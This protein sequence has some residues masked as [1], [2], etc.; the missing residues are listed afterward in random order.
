MDFVT[1]ISCDDIMAEDRLHFDQVVYFGPIEDIA[2]L[3]G[4]ANFIVQMSFK[5]R[6]QYVEQNAGFFYNTDLLCA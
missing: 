2:P 6:F 1:E 5:D 4:K 3:E